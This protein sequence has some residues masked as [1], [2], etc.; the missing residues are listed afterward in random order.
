[1]KIGIIA[2]PHRTD[3]SSRLSEILEWLEDHDCEPVV[4]D[5][6][7]EGFDLDSVQIARREDIPRLV[8]AIIVFGGD[9]TLL[10]VARS[11]GDS[12]TPIL[13]VNLGS[14]GFL[15][16]V[17]VDELYPAVEQ[18]LAGQHRIE[19]RWL[20]KTEIVPVQG[21]ATTYHALNDVVINKG[22]ISRIINLETYIQDDFTATFLADGIIVATPTGSTAYS[23][24]AG[25]PIVFPTLDSVILTPICPH[26]LTNR[27][28][29]V[30]ADTKIRIVLSSGKDVMLTVDGQVGTALQEGD[31][32]WF[33]RSPFSIGL[34]QSKER[35]YFDILRKKLKWA[36][37]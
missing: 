17:T 31:E 8:Q 21:T 16:E 7:A 32:I 14:L 19:R 20:L 18:I 15:T 29:V 27:P 2:K 11:V 30:P 9:G 35:S 6:V 24:S 23:L 10:S 3:F 25:G 4:E 26:T 13:G 33:T 12:G 22:A 34:I 28:L 1:M 37:R 36:E 5:S